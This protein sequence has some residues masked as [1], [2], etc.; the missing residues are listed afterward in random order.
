ML[1]ARITAAA[2]ASLGFSLHVFTGKGFVSHV[3][4]VGPT[5]VRSPIATNAPG[6]VA[7]VGRL[8]R[9][10]QADRNSHFKEPV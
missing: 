9:C 7:W 6:C 1:A 2:N 8:A 5:T 10:V 3:V 4:R